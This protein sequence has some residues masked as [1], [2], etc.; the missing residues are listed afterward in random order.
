LATETLGVMISCN[1]NGS[2]DRRYWH[3][4]VFLEASVH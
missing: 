3:L 2:H 4:I 1:D